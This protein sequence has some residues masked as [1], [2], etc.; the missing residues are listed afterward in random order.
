M[1]NKNFGVIT[2]FC[3]FFSCTVLADKPSVESVAIEVAKAINSKSGAVAQA[4]GKNVIITNVIKTSPNKSKQWLDEHKSLVYQDLVP[5][6]CRN[7]SSN[8]AFKDGLFYTFVYVS[9][10]GQLLAEIVVNKQ[11]CGI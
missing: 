6:V 2:L 5:Q 1:I 9:D 10:S 8:P 11:V 4:K 3:A 7:N